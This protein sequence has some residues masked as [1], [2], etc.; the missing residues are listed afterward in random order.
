MK[1]EYQIWVTIESTQLYGQWI[2][3]SFNTYNNFIK[4]LI[5]A[6]Y[7]ITTE[8]IGLHEFVKANDSV[9]ASVTERRF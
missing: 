3:V 4:Q 5:L 9:I 6:N 7:E 2:E 1:K 8:K